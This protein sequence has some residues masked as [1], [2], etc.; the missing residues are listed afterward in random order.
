MKIACP[1]EIGLQLGY[2]DRAM[3][4]GRAASMGST[5]YASYLRRMAA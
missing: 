3:V 4:L 2:L 1:E 5:D